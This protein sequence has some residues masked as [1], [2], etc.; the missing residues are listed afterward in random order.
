VPVAFVTVRAGSEVTGGELIAFGRARL[1]GYKV[2]K[3]VV[4]GELPR[5]STGKIRK[6]ALREQAAGAVAEVEKD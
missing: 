1:A 5:T 6:N 4:F 2:P 3:H